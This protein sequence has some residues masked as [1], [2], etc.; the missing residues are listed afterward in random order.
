MPHGVASE[1]VEDWWIAADQAVA[2]LADDTDLRMRVLLAVTSAGYRSFHRVTALLDPVPD[3]PELIRARFELV[4]CGRLSRSE[5]GELVRLLRPALE[6]LDP[7]VRAAQLGRLAWVVAA[8]GDLH[9]ARKLCHRSGKQR[10]LTATEH[11]RVRVRQVDFHAW[12]GPVDR[13]HDLVE[14]ID[15]P[16]FRAEAL[17]CIARRCADPD[18]MRDAV[19]CAKEAPAEVRDDALA[20]VYRLALRAAQHALAERVAKKLAPARRGRPLAE[21]ALAAAENGRGTHART[22]AVKALLDGAWP[23][24]LAAVGRILGSAVQPLVDT[25]LRAHGYPVRSLIGSAGDGK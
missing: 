14:M 15:D 22:L 9:Y 11:A 1:A 5:T 18:L 2:E 25:R 6:E 20:A 8:T 21:L 19:E 7:V 13:A 17:A 3:G 16:R 12:F 4:E 23:L 24:P 10:D